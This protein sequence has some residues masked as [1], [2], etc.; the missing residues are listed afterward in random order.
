MVPVAWSGYI[1]PPLAEKM[2]NLSTGGTIKTLVMFQHQ[3]DIPS[4][5]QQLKREHATLAERNRRVLEAL[6]D[7]A[8]ADQPQMVSYFEQLKKR[9]VVK[10]YR[11]L[12]IANMVIV[13]ASSEGIQALAERPEF[14]DLYLSYPIE[15]IPAVKAKEPE[16][17]L[18]TRRE[19]G[20]DKIH[21]PEAWALGYTGLGRVIS[22]I[23]TGVSGIHPAL[24]ARFRGD[25]DDD[26]DIDESWYDP[27][28]TH[29]LQ[30]TDSGYH[31]THTMGTICG[32]SNTDTIGVAIN[33]KWIAAAAIDRGGGLTRTIADA[34]LSFQ[35]IADPDGNPY[36]QDN[37]DACG[38]SWGVPDNAG[39]ADCNQSFWTVIDNCEAAGTVV[40]FSAGN[41]GAGGL[42]S[43]ADRATTIYNCFS[44]GAVNGNY[45]NLPIADFSA[46]GP[47]ECATG[48]LAIK[49]E[50]VAPGVAIRSSVPGGGYSSLD[51]TSMASPHVTGT[52]ALI[53]QA[54][55]NLDVDAIKEI[56]MLTAHDLPL[57]SPNGEDNI[58]GHG[59]IDAYQACLLAQSYGYIEGYVYNGLSLPIRN[60]DI[61]VVGAPN[62]TT[63]DTNG[64]YFLSVKGDTS[65]TIKASFFGYIPDSVVLNV[66]SNDTITHNFALVSAV[67]GSVSGH[68]RDINSLPIADAHVKIIG[69][70]LSP[71]IT[72]SLGYYIINNIVANS[73]YAVQASASGY[74]TGINNVNVLA[75][76][77]VTVDF[78]LQ[79]LESFEVDDGG[80]NGSGNW[81]WG[82]PTSGPNAAY[83]GQKVWAT[84]LSG[85]YPNNADDS[86][87]T[88]YYTIDNPNATFTFYHWY[89][90]ESGFD[91]GNVSISTNGGLSWRILTPD[92]GYPDAN[93]TGLDDSSGYTGESDGWI[94][95]VFP[96]GD[97]MGQAVKFLFRS[98]SDGSLADPGWYIDAIALN[99]GTAWGDLSGTL[100][101]ITPASLNVTTDSGRTISFP[102]TMTNGGPGLLVYGATAIPDFLRVTRG[103]IPLSIEGPKETRVNSIPAGKSNA[104]IELLSTGGGSVITNSG[105]PDVFGYA[106][107]DSHEP[108]GPVFSWVD[109]STR[110]TP[111]T[112]L[113]DDTNVGPL[114]IGFEFPF[115]GTFYNTFYF[116]TNG[117]ISFTEASSSVF[118]NLPFPTQGE[119][120]L[121]AVAPFWD[122]L[123]FIVTG[124]AY[125]YSNSDSLMVSWRG[126]PHVGSGGPYTFE[127]ILL[128]SGEIIFQYYNMAS[129]LNNCTVGIQNESGSD[130][131]QVVYNG[132]YLENNLAIEFKE[133]ERWISVTPDGGYMTP[134]NQATLNVGFNTTA[135]SVG[136]YTGMVTI[137]TN[138]PAHANVVVPCTLN[139][140]H[141]EID[142]D[143]VIPTDFS[144]SQNFPNPFNPLTE[145]S[146]GLSVPGI[147]SLEIYDIMGRRVKTLVN[148]NRLA[149]LHKA[150][151]DSSND[152][153]EKV[154]SGVYL[155]KLAQG[156]NV[157]TRKMVMLK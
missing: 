71:A 143:Q 106:W 65:Y 2:Q 113:E 42:R 96:I 110:G 114:D 61:S 107:K 136:T 141:T 73:S 129:P 7:A 104:K 12:W 99:G 68:V 130:G 138:D 137:H 57:N 127:L 150:I 54:N 46:R 88:Q 116:C 8:N 90:Y 58:Y 23:D 44:V 16:P 148:E 154:A 128:E 132:S 70:P 38:N 151:W 31:G 25:A 117:W 115:Y 134:G 59:I 152:H 84:N 98:G 75:N 43:P 102:L 108:G 39:Y 15:N 13:E 20:L 27:Y 93:V 131:L 60:A 63:A 112:G 50:V 34:I 145:I 21:A 153:G 92:G 121:A 144:L 28:T 95:A 103:P 140:I 10:D 156:N 53:R 82:V 120:P 101:N 155:Y 119:S 94:E 4:L 139:V 105:G 79:A 1:T 22:N 83:D 32:R 3:A 33:A 111:L 100:T 74:S 91:G 41:E 133:I 36:T 78:S 124:S 45:A 26:G 86:L 85:N 18:I 55:P 24:S 126:V 49:P 67:N 9:G 48:E 72:D 97:Y 47:S 118:N 62:A 77:T 35:W 66:L 81:Q 87:I 146:F 19:V 29:Y 11:M 142:G 123:T 37:P 69:T 76:D 14:A 6:R 64:Y 40:I 5:N 89:H 109:I 51:G 147:V 125:Y 122:D 30:P 157:I 149:G 52:V 17:S 135:L 80:W 56:L